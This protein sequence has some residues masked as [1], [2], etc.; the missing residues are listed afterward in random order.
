MAF[1]FAYISQTLSW[2]RGPPRCLPSG[3]K[4]RNSSKYLLPLIEDQ[5]RDSLRRQETVKTITVLLHQSTAEKTV[6]CLLSAMSAKAEGEH[7]R[8]PCEAVTR[9]LSA[10]LSWHQRKPSRELGFHPH[11][12]L[13]HPRPTHGMGGNYM[14]PEPPPLHGSNKEPPR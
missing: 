2:R 9:C 13:P 7:R 12:L 5:E 11:R 3:W 4:Q 14:E 1:L 6:A 8:L 10:P